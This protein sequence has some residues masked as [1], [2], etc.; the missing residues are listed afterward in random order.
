MEDTAV[1]KKCSRC[2][3][4]SEYHIHSLTH[5]ESHQYNDK[6]HPQ[7]S[8]FPP[9]P[10]SNQ[11]PYKLLTATPSHSQVPTK[12]VHARPKRPQ[13]TAVCTPEAGCA[14]GLD[15]RCMYPPHMLGCIY[16]C[17]VRACAFLQQVPSTANTYYSYMAMY[18]ATN[19]R[20][21]SLT[22]RGGGGGATY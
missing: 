16:G 22:M 13:S 10:T 17:D 8:P 21:A 11:Q 7:H 2:L 14:F 15:S 9:G 20:K 5:T 12:A 4:I 18:V 3:N 1:N 6:H 19:F